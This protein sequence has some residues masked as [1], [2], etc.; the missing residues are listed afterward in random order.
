MTAEFLDRIGDWLYLVFVQKLDFWAIVGLVAQAMF[1]GRFLIQWLASEKAGRSVV[2]NAFWLFSIGGGLL[3][4]IYAIE[5]SDPV[6][7]LGQGLGLVVYIRNMML[8]SKA[9]KAGLE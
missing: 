1:T 6:F 9:K 8:I 7:I 4:F 2:P 3:L 5:R